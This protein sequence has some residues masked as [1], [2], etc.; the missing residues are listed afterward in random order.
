MSK[1]EEIKKSIAV[2]ND[3]INK[4]VSNIEEDIAFG[5]DKYL[6]RIEGDI[7][8]GNICY[9]D[10]LTK[11]E[12]T[13]CKNSCLNLNLYSKLSNSGKYYDM[14][15]PLLLH[16]LE[17]YSQRKRNVSISEQTIK[18]LDIDTSY[19]FTMLIKNIE[20]KKIKLKL[21][22]NC[23]FHFN[24]YIIAE[25]PKFED[26]KKYE[27]SFFNS[28]W[29]GYFIYY[30]SHAKGFVNGELFHVYTEFIDFNRGNKYTGMPNLLRDIN[31]NTINE[32][33]LKKSNNSIHNMSNYNTNPYQDR[34]NY[35][36]DSDYKKEFY[37]KFSDPW[38][39]RNDVEK[40]RHIVNEFGEVFSE[41]QVKYYQKL[42][43]NITPNTNIH[44]SKTTNQLLKRK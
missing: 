2:L 27:V 21:L 13:F 15:D 30:K 16:Y 23:Y 20:D 25:E 9:I 42:G 39:V 38:K 5:G 14:N 28:K 31:D 44:G 33:Y 1:L 26:K 18:E 35:E 36:N 24:N 4:S 17:N 41:E 3:L 40:N 6:F 43:H 29:D 22:F 32:N 11:K 34:N 37:H 7:D 10:D 8:T 12:V 19:T